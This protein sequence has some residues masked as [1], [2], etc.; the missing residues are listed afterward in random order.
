MRQVEVTDKKLL[1]KTFSYF[2]AY[3]DFLSDIKSW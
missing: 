3:N 2:Q 1:S